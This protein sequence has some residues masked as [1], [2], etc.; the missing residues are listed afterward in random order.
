MKNLKKGKKKSTPIKPQTMTLP[1]SKE[2]LPD[3]PEHR[4]PDR[5]VRQFRWTHSR[6]T[7]QKSHKMD[8]SNWISGLSRVLVQGSVWG[9]LRKRRSRRS[10]VSHLSFT[11]DLTW[12][13]VLREQRYRDHSVNIYWTNTEAQPSPNM[14]WETDE[15]IIKFI[16]QKCGNLDVTKVLMGTLMF[17]CW[18]VH[19]TSIIKRFKH[20]QLYCTGIMKSFL[21]I[22]FSSR[23]ILS[24]VEK[25]FINKK[26]ILG[27][28]L[29]FSYTRVFILQLLSLLVGE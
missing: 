21:S 27:W 5:Q 15:V 26:N 14:S 16:I 2:W 22:S 24:K 19:N 12:T 13:C 7:W 20:I 28:L 23:L 4:R 3:V 10:S 6:V 8:R 17:L 9:P 11:H 25:A 18:C 1:P 29:N